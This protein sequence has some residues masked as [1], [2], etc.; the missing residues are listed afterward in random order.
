VAE[1]MHILY[2]GNWGAGKLIDAASDR[3]LQRRQRSNYRDGVNLGRKLFSVLPENNRIVKREQERWSLENQQDECFAVYVH[4][5]EITTT[6]R[7]I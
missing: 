1:L 4:P 6:L 7:H 5:Q 2:M 3:S